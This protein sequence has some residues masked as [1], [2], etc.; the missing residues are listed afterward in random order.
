MEGGPIGQACRQGRQAGGQADSLPGDGQ[1]LEGNP[2]AEV[3][4]RVHGWAGTGAERQHTQPVQQACAWVA[5]PAN[6]EHQ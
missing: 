4:P 2:R 1:Q 6:G 3:A 5:W